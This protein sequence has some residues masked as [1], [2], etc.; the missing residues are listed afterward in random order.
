MK[1]LSKWDI[2][3]KT[4]TVQVCSMPTISTDQS[5]VLKEK[6][7]H[8]II[9]CYAKHKYKNISPFVL[10]LILENIGTSRI[11]AQYAKEFF[12]EYEKRI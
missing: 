2:Y 8:G 3:A 4:S 12:I 1:S 11:A 6:R 7:H 5:T 9:A 10:V